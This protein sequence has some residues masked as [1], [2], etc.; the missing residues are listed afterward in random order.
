[1][2]RERTASTPE[3]EPMHR[4]RIELPDGRYLVFYTFEDLPQPPR[5]SGEHDA[6]TSA[7]N[8]APDA[9]EDHRV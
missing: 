8:D 7:R 4:R 2:E 5:R 1:M 6:E 9:K 3:T